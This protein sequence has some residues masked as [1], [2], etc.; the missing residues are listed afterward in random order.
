M[1]SYVSKIN[2]CVL[3]LKIFFIGDKFGQC[4]KQ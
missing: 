4:S 1:A 3:E 2:L